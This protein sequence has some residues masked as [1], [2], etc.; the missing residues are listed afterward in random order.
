[1]HR[2]L[3]RGGVGVARVSAPAR[4]A[5]IALRHGTLCKRDEV[6]LVEMPLQATGWN[7]RDDLRTILPR[8]HALRDIVDHIV[9]GVSGV[10]FGVRA[11]RRP[12]WF[13]PSLHLR[14]HG[15]TVG[16]LEGRTLYIPDRQYSRS[17]TA[18]IREV[19]WNGQAD[20]GRCRRRVVRWP[21]VE[22]VHYRIGWEALSSLD[23]PLA[24]L[25]R[26]IS[27]L[28]G[29][30]DS[31]GDG[32]TLQEPD[33]TSSASGTPTS[34]VSSSYVR[35]FCDYHRYDLRAR[36]VEAW[37][38]A[39]VNRSWESVWEALTALCEAGQRLGS[40]RDIYDLPPR[41]LARLRVARLK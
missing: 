15:P 7:I 10:R 23:Q 14:Q 11:H 28:V 30:D 32:G 9:S 31:H 18:V 26:S 2:G 12:T 35:C 39:D 16:P 19:V 5:T 3:D 37:V 22:V 8:F 24:G 36:W 6:D 20:R 1:M 13:W 38:P 40:C 27:W 4:R 33:Q 17:R 34:R 41:E 21:D 25:R 29:D